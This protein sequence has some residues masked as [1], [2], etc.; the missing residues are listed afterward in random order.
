MIKYITSAKSSAEA[1][2]FGGSASLP[3]Q[4]WTLGGKKIFLILSAFLLVCAACQKITLKQEVPSSPKE[5][6]EPL[7]K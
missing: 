5:S 6:Y 4:S 1:E 7:P 2:R 3:K